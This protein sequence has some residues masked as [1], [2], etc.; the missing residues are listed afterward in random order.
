MAAVTSAT[1]LVLY[2]YDTCPYCFRVRRALSR[3]GVEIEMRNIYGDPKHMRDLVDARGVKTVPVLRIHRENGPDEWMAE[4]SD[5][6][7]YLEE[8]FGSA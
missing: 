1:D 3:L 2:H 8:R 5:I 6:I 4:S 7:A